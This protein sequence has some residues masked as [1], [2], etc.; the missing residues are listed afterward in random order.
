MKI[1]QIVNIVKKYLLWIT[2]LRFDKIYLFTFIYGYVKIN[3]SETI[4]AVWYI[5][6]TL[7]L[8]HIL[9]TCFS[10]CKSISLII[11][12]IWYKIQSK[13]TSWKSRK[14]DWFFIG[15]SRTPRVLYG[16]CK[17]DFTCLNWYAVVKLIINLK[18]MWKV[19]DFTFYI[20]L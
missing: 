6:V 1:I 14:I 5:W 11:Q 13:I 15:C 7:T 17:S 10:I 4:K 8:Y 12:S 3:K 20:K 2:T 9:C 16:C 18:L 19:M